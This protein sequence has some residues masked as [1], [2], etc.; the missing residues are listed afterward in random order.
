MSTEKTNKTFSFKDIQGKLEDFRQKRDDLNKKTRDYIKNLQEIDNE[1]NNTLIKARDFYKK[2]RDFWNQKVKKLKGKKIE[3]K[4]LLDTLIETQKRLQKI[5][6]SGKGNKRFGSFKQIERKIENLERKIETE[7]LELTEENAIIDKIKELA[8][9]KQKLLTEEKGDEL[10][11]TERKIEIVKINLN[12]IYEQLNKWS[13]K[14]QNNHNKM[15]ELY[16]KVKNLRDNKRQMEEELI[17]NKKAADQ[18]H[19]KFLKIMNQKKRLN[20]EN[21]KKSS[22]AKNYQGKQ[23]QRSRAKSFNNNNKIIEKMK[24]D[25][26]ASALEKQKAGKKLDLYEARLI[27]EQGK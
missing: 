19:E 12:K 22:R 2:K 17:E 14:S 5:S 23:H 18:Y 20:R 27:L 9:I 4:N 21:S 25:K 13:E 15:Q 10:Y 1:V 26:L 6:N 11:K 24:Q 16:E 3:Y 8:I 7:N